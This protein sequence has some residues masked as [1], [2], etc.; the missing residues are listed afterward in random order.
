MKGYFLDTNIIEFWFDPRRPEHEAVCKQV[1]DLP[2]DT[3]LMTSVVVIGEIEYGIHANKKGKQIALAEWRAILTPENR[4]ARILKIAKSTAEIYGD[5]RARLFEKYAGSKKR[6]RL[7]PEQ[8]LDPMTSL[9]LGIQ[10][11]DLW[12]AA[13]A[14]ERNLV[15]VT[16][17]RMY[18]IREIAPELTIKDWAVPS[19]QPPSDPTSFVAPS[20]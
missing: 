17:D 7:R 14:M 9:S 16:H 18:R 20:T 3:P 13:Q 11:N 2:A 12:L 5:L 4:L 6:N 15:L 1:N 19:T 10:E 8:L